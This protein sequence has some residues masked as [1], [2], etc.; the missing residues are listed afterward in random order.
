VANLK[1]PVILDE[2]EITALIQLLNSRIVQLAHDNPN[3]T[4][5][6]S[7]ESGLMKKL[8]EIRA[9]GIASARALG[10]LK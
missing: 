9:T 8:L 1:Y 3:A 4:P 7:F 6:L 2:D 5:V 10:T